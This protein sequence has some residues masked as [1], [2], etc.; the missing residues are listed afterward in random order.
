MELHG[1]SDDCLR[2]YG[3]VVYARACDTDGNI[4]VVLV[5]S[6]SRVAPL[7]SVSLPR[8]ELQG[9]VLLAGLMKSV[10]LP[11]LELQ[12]AV[13]LAGLMKRVKKIH[14]LRWSTFIANRVSKIH[15]ISLVRDWYKIEGRNNPAD[16]VSRS[17]YPSEVKTSE[18]WFKGPKF[19]SNLKESWPRITT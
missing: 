10:S 1:F 17:M 7:K 16:I 5:A 13:L 3:A 19:L 15:S 18:L 9:A 12:G 4:A 11:R 8:L 2:A 14:V 6:V